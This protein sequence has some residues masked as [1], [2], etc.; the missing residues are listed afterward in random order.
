MI[1]TAAN[2]RL[3]A[4]MFSRI[5]AGDL[6][7]GLALLGDDFVSHN[8]RVPH[9]PA[10]TSGKEAFAAFFRGPEGQRL[11][12]STSEVVRTLADGDLVA[13]HSRIVADPGAELAAVDILRVR[14]GM[15]VEHWD[16]V[17]PVPGSLP[18]PHGMF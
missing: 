13:L 5:T 18:H 8:P 15:V 17:Q 10:V 9:D 2:R 7:G 4:E 16:V 3:V 6:D 11:L 1:D 14:D 12:A